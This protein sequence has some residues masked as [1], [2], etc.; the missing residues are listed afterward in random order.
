M[1]FGIDNSSSIHTDNC[2][3]DFFV[4]GEEKT[5]YIN[6]SVGTVETKFIIKFTKAN[7]KFFFSYLHVNKTSIS[8]FKAPDNIPSNEFCLKDVSKDFT[9]DEMSGTSLNGTLYT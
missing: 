7:A 1:I 8:K 5:E 2:R 4:L 6:D 9:K 3:N